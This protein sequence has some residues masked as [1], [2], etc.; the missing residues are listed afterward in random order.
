MPIFAWCKRHLNEIILIAVLSLLCLKNYTPGTF[1]IGWD[2]LM[3]ELNLGLNLKRSFLAVWQEYQGLGLVGGMAHATDLVRQL[4]IL[5]LTL[6]LPVRLI[7][8]F[9][10]FAML[11]LGT[12]GIYFGLKKH[13]SKKLIPLA[14]ALFYLLN[15][16][17]VQYFRV[18]LES[19]S[20]FW[21]FFPWLIF[22]FWDFLENKKHLKK[23]IILNILAIPSFHVQTIFIVYLL[24]ISLIL[25]AHFITRPKISHLPSYLS[26]YLIIFLINSFWLLPQLYFLKTN[27]QNPTAGIGN[28]MSNDETFARNQARGNLSDFLLLR[29]YYYD[30]PSN[31][32]ALLAAW[33]QHFSNHYFLLCGYLLSFVVILGFIS[34]FTHRHTPKYIKI[35]LIFLLL[36]SALTLLSNQFPFNLLNQ[37]LRSL[38]IINQIFRSPWTKFL[39]PAAFLFSYLFALGLQLLYQIATQLKYSSFV[40]K[41]PIFLSLLCLYFFSQPSFSGDY[42]SPDVRQKI[43]QEYMEIFNFFQSQVAPTARIANLPQGSFW[44]WTNYKWNLSGSGFI[45]YAIPQPILD[46]AFDTWNLKNEQYYWELSHAI[47]SQD[48]L[49]LNNVFSKY[50]IEYIIFDNNIYFPDENIY[51]KLSQPTKN[52]LDSLP[53]LILVKQTKNISV[54]QTNFSTKIA[55]TSQL[56]SAPA[57]DFALA[58]YDYQRLGDYLVDHQASPNFNNY[59]TSRL[60]SELNF[61]PNSLL[62]TENTLVTQSQEH[63]DT[64]QNIFAFHFPKAS[65][66]QNYL[67]KINSRHE[68]GLPLK[69]SAISDNLLNKYFETLLPTSP[70]P[71]TSWFYIPARQID[72]FD[73]G[74][75]FI[76]N[77]TSFHEANK[78]YIDNITVYNLFSS[79]PNYPAP[80]NRHYLDSKNSIFYY[81]INLDSPAHTLILPQSYSSG[82]LAFYRQN[83]KIHLLKNHYLLNNWANAWELPDA[84]CTGQVSP[85]PDIYI[86]FWPQLLQFLGFGLLII[87]LFWLLKNSSDSR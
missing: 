34:L 11:F 8:Y 10:H 9:W 71:A 70:N 12:F 62:L 28:F 20:T 37:A 67:V 81:K 59:F 80:L 69:I 3:P 14:A 29:G 7:R 21:G 39:V 47:Q 86:L 31:N 35:S 23:L 57:F 77:N 79:P 44:G 16:G 26:I 74:L 72:T 24:C 55:T 54:Y 48:P 32:T 27:L 85:C 51:G 13:L 56:P 15:F 82:W 1:L 83:G 25:L 41:L 6:I 76:F 40:A 78:N 49:L 53:N 33:Q 61:D 65:L 50:F 42:F 4:L 64:T 19:F 18:P 68:A 38:P 36:L 43:P 46:R 75:N 22:T 2:N 63:S 60:Q 58:D 66:S 30:F 45:W 73:Y 84:L 5:P 87:T 17:S 52:L